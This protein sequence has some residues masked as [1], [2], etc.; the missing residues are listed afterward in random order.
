M[1]LVIS[2]EYRNNTEL[3]N[4]FQ[5]YCDY[6]YIIY[7]NFFI[8]LRWLL[9]DI[10]IVKIV[11]GHTLY[12]QQNVIKYM[13]TDNIRDKPSL[14]KH[15]WDIQ[16]SVHYNYTI[17][18]RKYSKTHKYFCVILWQTIHIL[19]QSFGQRIEREFGLVLRWWC[20]HY[21]CENQ[22]LRSVE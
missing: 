16:R 14:Q 13:L 10:Q 3:V 4:C 6:M 20:I 18:R 12:T 1:N 11:C 2:Q 21:S 22:W 5:I 15:N 17:T 9:I 7:L 8:V 19:W